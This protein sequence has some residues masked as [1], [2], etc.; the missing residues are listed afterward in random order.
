[1]TILPLEIEKF[2]LKMDEAKL[3]LANSILHSLAEVN[4]DVNLVFN[5]TQ[6]HRIYS[7]NK[8][9][10]IAEYMAKYPVMLEI[11]HSL[12]IIC[13]TQAVRTH[14]YTSVDYSSPISTFNKTE[15]LNTY[16]SWEGYSKR[17]EISISMR[18]SNS[19]G[20]YTDICAGISTMMKK[21]HKTAKQMQQ[22]SLAEKI[23]INAK[24]VELNK[25]I[26][27]KHPTYVNPNTAA[28]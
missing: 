4:T 8:T 19:P 28:S 16:G 17:R 24:I 26:L 23:L 3:Q 14:S 11:S 27:E 15:Y 21:H 6:L 18:N 2:N 9:L 20:S 5:P 1:M 7:T 10:Q 12:I 13:D 25:A 22:T